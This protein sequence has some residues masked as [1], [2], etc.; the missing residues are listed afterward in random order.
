MNCV[1]IAGDVMRDVVVRPRGPIRRDTDTPAEIELH[2][3]GSAANTAMWVGHLGY[4]VH[5]CARVGRGDA[6]TYE[7][8]AAR[9]GVQVHLFEDADRHTGTIVVLIDGD[10][11]TMVTDRGANLALSPADISRAL[12]QDARILHL[13]GYTFFHLVDPSGWFPLMDQVRSQGG[14]VIVDTSSI[15]FLA[16][17]GVERWWAI[18]S[19]ASILRANHDEAALLTGETDALRQVAAM[20]ERGVVAIVTRGAEGASW[21]EPGGTP[22]SLPARPLG[23]EGLV[24]PT[25]AGDAFSAGLIAGVFEGRPLHDAIQSGLDL[26]ATV[27]SRPGAGPS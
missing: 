24:D 26:S 21:C 1:V 6:T 11:R 8:F 23:P 20:S 16:D 17:Y 15:G 12:I 10:T 13:T 2:F 22:H 18:A 4:P 25:G 7:Q 19:H 3:G 5:F 14:E 27:V 9:H